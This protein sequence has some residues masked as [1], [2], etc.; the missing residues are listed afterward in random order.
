MVLQDSYILRDKIYEAYFKQENIQDDSELALYVKSHIMIIDIKRLEQKLFYG[1]DIYN[2]IIERKNNELYN[3][4]NFNDT[5]EKH[6]EHILNKTIMQFVDRQ[7]ITAIEE[8]KKLQH[9]GL[10]PT[11]LPKIAPN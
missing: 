6:E 10:M 3:H 5:N 8:I 2:D 4:F 1:Y 7:C 11:R 9:E